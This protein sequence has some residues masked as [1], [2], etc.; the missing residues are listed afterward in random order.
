MPGCHGEVCAGSLGTS[1]A[2]TRVLFLA[3]VLFFQ[4]LLRICDGGVGGAALPL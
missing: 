3:L 2:Q 4:A 1:K